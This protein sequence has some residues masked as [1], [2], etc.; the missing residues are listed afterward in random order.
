MNHDLEDAIRYA[1]EPETQQGHFELCIH[2]G[3]FKHSLGE[4]VCRT[5]PLEMPG[6][7]R[8]ERRRANSYTIE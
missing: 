3:A 1:L 7:E 2:C 8:D 5:T 4:H 6:E